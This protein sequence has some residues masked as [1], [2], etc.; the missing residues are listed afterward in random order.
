M[1]TF[2]HSFSPKA[3]TSRKIREVIRTSQGQR[4]LRNRTII[5]HLGSFKYLLA[6][7]KQ[8]GVLVQPSTRSLQIPEVSG[9]G[10]VEVA[11]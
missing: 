4:N 8:R 10:D 1:Q 7:T 2:I 3:I 6:L 5:I 11:F 9:R